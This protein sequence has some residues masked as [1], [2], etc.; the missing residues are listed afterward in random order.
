MV[1]YLNKA[2]KALGAPELVLILVVMEDGLVRAKVNVEQTERTVL[3]LVVVDNGL[4]KSRTSKT[5]TAAL[6]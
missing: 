6:A 1:S 5:A 4:V 2:R 3:I